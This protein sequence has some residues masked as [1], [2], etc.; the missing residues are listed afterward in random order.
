MNAVVE[1]AMEEDDEDEELVTRRKNVIHPFRVFI[2][3][4][5]YRS[6]GQRGRGRVSCS[7]NPSIVRALENAFYKAFKYLQ[8]TNKKCLIAVD[9][10]AFMAQ[11]V[12][13]VR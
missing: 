13:G 8:P 5:M 12:L 2:T 9:V 1:E 7:P 6:G 10:S 11:E 4:Q 3:L